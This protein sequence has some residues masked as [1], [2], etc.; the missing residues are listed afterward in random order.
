MGKSVPSRTSAPS[1]WDAVAVVVIVFVAPLVAQPPGPSPES[2]TASLVDYLKAKG[3]PSSLE[4][5]A[6]LY[7]EYFPGRR[8]TGSA[9][10]NTDL[11]LKLLAEDKA[12]VE[13][14]RKAQGQIDKASPKQPA[15]VIA[16]KA[17]FRYVP[18]AGFGV[19][20]SYVV[21]VSASVK[22]GAVRDRDLVVAVDT[23]ASGLGTLDC[24]G[25]A[26]V[27]VGGKVVQKIDLKKA[28]FPTIQAAAT[29]TAFL[30]AE[31]G[32]VI[33]TALGKPVRVRVEVHPLVSITSGVVPLWP[34]T[35]ELDL[36]K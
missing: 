13:A 14:T 26:E 19:N 1:R 10:Q 22:K 8:Y 27:E 5:R 35:V 17:F 20:G 36:A 6:V 32:T 2:I 33:P 18:A 4:D 31:K 16:E 12:A 28:W 21:R 30:Y 23:P 24:T 9:A 25:T 15:E 34:G 11:L 29:K 7:G 3:K